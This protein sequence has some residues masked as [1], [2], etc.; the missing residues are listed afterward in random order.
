M[1]FHN[2][3]YIITI[4]I[5]L[6]FIHMTFDIDELISLMRSNTNDGVDSELGEQEAAG[7]ASTGGGGGGKGY[8]TVTKWE[9]GLTRG[10]ANTIDPK[11]KWS[12]L[13]TIKRG[14]G[15]TLL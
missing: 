7:G 5:I 13:Y 9:T 10:V 8:P 11:S 4:S 2:Y 12:S 3:K 15:N 14:K 6:I 1:S